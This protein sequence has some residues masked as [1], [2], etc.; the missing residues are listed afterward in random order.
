MVT[1]YFSNR[2]FFNAPLECCEIVIWWRSLISEGVPKGCR[3]RKFFNGQLKHPQT[4]SISSKNDVVSQKQKEA[5]A[6]KEAKASK[7]KE[8]NKGDFHRVSTGTLA[9]SD[10]AGPSKSDATEENIVLDKSPRQCNVIQIPVQV[11]SQSSREEL[12][13]S[14]DD[15]NPSLRLKRKLEKKPENITAIQKCSK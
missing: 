3:A 9:V 1:G 12:S 5:K 11:D 8:K 13:S 10:Q 14:E 4:T 15:W 7:F 2:N 6:F